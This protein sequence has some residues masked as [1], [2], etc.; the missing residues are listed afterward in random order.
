MATIEGAKALHLENEIGSI[1]AGK[2]ADMVLLDLDTYSN[3]YSDSDETIYSDIVFSSTA[4]NVR[5]V[6]V[7]GRWLVK[8][9]QSTVYDHME[10]VSNGKKELANLLKRI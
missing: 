3:S 2:K 8:E 7:D 5:C 4:E 9:R 10:I 6:M 1:E